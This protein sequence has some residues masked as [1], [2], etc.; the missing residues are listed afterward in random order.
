[1]IFS[2]DGEESFREAETKVLKEIGKHHSLIVATGGGVVINSENWGVLHQGIVVWLN[3]ERNRL[4]D[5]LQKDSAQRP[6]L[7]QG[8]LV[9]SIDEIFSQRKSFYKE[10]DLEISIKDESPKE[11]AQKIIRLLL[12]K[13]TDSDDPDVQQTI[14]E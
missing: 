1:M 14:G 4:I 10:S 7:L 13:V 12:E 11:V 3:P 6:L 2:E 8:N 5:R 9:V